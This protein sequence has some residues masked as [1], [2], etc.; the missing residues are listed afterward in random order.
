[1]CEKEQRKYLES[2]FTPFH[3]SDIEMNISCDPSK[4]YRLLNICGFPAVGILSYHKLIQR[5]EVAYFYL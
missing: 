2:M 1:M 3:L 4:C 5:S